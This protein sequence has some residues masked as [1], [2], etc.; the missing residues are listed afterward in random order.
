M[1]SLA[2]V[3]A[4]LGA[5]AAGQPPSAAGPE[6]PA[7]IKDHYRDYNFVNAFSSVSERRL[8]V[9][10]R[11]DPSDL[12][13]ARVARAMRRLADRTDAVD[14]GIVVPSGRRPSETTDRA[15][16]LRVTSFDLDESRGEAW[17]HLEALALDRTTN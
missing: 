2:I 4:V 16:L 15:D 3:F 13:L 9:S 1:S 17:L 7:E 11:V 14:P 10:R 8:V 12:R 6:L 5:V